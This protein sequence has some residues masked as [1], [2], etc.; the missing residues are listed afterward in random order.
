MAIN[1]RNKFY[2]SLRKQYPIFTYHDYHY[3]LDKDKNLNITF[4]FSI[5]ESIY[6]HPQS[7]IK[8]HTAFDY[9]YSNNMLSDIEN[10]VFHIGMIELI[11]YWKSTC[12]PTIIIKAGFLDEKAIQWWKKLYY[13][14]L[15]EFFYCNNIKPNIKNFVTIN[16]QSKNKFERKA[17]FFTNETIIP[18][19]GGK[20]SVVT[21]ELLKN[22]NNIPLI[23]NPRGA[24]LACVEKGGYKGNFINIQRTIDDNLLKLND[25]G[26]LNGHTPFSAMLAF[27]TIL[28][29]VISC[30]KNI[31]LSNE[32]SANEATVKDSWI[33]HQY[34]KSITFESDFRNYVHNYIDENINYYS[35]LRPLNEIQIALLFSQFSTY[36][37]VFKSCNVGSK[38]D[39]WCC[40]CSKCLFAFIILS[41]FMTPA[42]LKNIFS[43]NL[44]D[45]ENLIPILKEL[46]GETEEKP[47]E[48]VGTIE[49]VCIALCETIKQYETLPPLL[50][51]FKNTSQYQMYKTISIQDFLTS[52]EANHFLTNSK[53]E[54]IKKQIK[55]LNIKD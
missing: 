7:V 27:Y 39:I 16:C 14:G 1:N 25:K 49:E 42:I 36:F 9:F 3:N 50:L 37:S 51:Y 30:K 40:N 13:Y 5:G 24:S 12:S 22:R 41:P 10:L 46:I 29:A 32:S 44:F 21:L 23:I 18:I 2:S 8:Y 26:F 20:D 45:N 19:G 17:Y 54:I 4:D 35:F 52:F 53:L 31:A 11:S 43:V 55:Q 47:F 28:T 33:N 38:T 6:F 34:S 48:C 15:G